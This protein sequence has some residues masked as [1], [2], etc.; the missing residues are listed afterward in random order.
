[1]E[2]LCLTL[3]PNTVTLKWLEDWWLA[4]GQALENHGTE[5]T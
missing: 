5:R 2:L 3:L 1:M 4:E